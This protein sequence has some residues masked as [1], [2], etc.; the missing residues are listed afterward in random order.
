MFVG[1]GD[2]A[3]RASMMPMFPSPPYNSDDNDGDFDE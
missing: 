3:V 1:W 2:G